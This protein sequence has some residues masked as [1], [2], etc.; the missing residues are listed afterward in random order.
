LAHT[1]L[2]NSVQVRQGG[3]FRLSDLLDA[4]KMISHFLTQFAE[5][6]RVFQEKVPSVGQCRGRRI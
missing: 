3:K 4:C 2:D 5:C 1:F 6:I